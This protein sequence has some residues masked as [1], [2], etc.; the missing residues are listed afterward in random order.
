MIISAYF[1]V[2]NNIVIDNK[3]EFPAAITNKTET[4]S[5]LITYQQE[6]KQTSE[7]AQAKAKVKLYK[8][9]KAIL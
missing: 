3:T 8:G 9:I 2:N 7:K 5:E 1:K 4:C 6:K